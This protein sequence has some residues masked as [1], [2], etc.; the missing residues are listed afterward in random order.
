MLI[1]SLQNDFLAR[2]RREQDV[3]SNN[4]GLLISFN[5]RR[6][7]ARDVVVNRIAAKFR[8]DAR[9]GERNPDNHGK[10]GCQDIVVKT[11]H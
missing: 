2:A 11:E 7:I 6:F 9:P 5:K 1:G 4:A 3:A 8:I 10:F